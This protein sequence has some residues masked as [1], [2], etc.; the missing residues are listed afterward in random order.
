M[1]MVTKKETK[2]GIVIGKCVQF[3]FLGHISAEI[4]RC[5]HIY[6]YRHIFCGHGASGVE[7]LEDRPDRRAEEAIGEVG[8]PGPASCAAEHGVCNKESGAVRAPPQTAS[9]PTGGDPCGVTSVRV[10][11]PTGGDPCGVTSASVL[12]RG[13]ARRTARGRGAW[14]PGG[15]ETARQVAEGT[16]PLLPGG[17]SGCDPRSVSPVGTP[18]RENSSWGPHVAKPFPG[19]GAASQDSAPAAGFSSLPLFLFLPLPRPLRSFGCAWDAL[20]ATPGR[21]GQTLHTCR[22]PAGHGPSP[23]QDP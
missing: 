18:P 19:S 15:R 6:A 20:C 11:R 23:P 22:R 7:V 8:R 17:A 1:H 5:T 9:G 10:L 16:A 2:H 13:P 3:S 4:T 21:G 12:L 14:W